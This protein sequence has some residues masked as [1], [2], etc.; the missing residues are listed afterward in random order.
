MRALP[1]LAV[2]LLLSA[3]RRTDSGGPPS[4]S[5]SDSSAAP[6]ALQTPEAA[7]ALPPASRTDA[8]SSCSAAGMKPLPPRTSPKLPPAVASK[9]ER[10]L[11]A[12]V[13]CDYE[14]LARLTREGSGSFKYSFGDGEDPATYWR[15]REEAG[16]PALAQL[17]RVLNLPHSSE[18]ISTLGTY[19]TWPSAYGQH[20][21]AADWAAVEGLYPPEQLEAWRRSEEG[22]VG[23]RVGI[24]ES[25]EWRFAVAGD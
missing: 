16:D 15:E 18:R 17:V 11:A 13:R 2:C 10:I 22:Y 23:L 3:C 24:H 6:T 19:Y 5:P 20:R 7:G 8:G 21:S 1:L 14:G 25:G 12:A 4:Q 9:R